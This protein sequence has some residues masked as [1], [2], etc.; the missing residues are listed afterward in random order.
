MTRALAIFVLVGACSG[1]DGGGSCPSYM[2]ISGGQ[3]SRTATRLTWTME[4][5][6]PPDTVTFNRTGVPPFVLEY[7]WAIDIDVDHDDDTDLRASVEHFREM[8]AAEVMTA[9]IL[10]VTNEGL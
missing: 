5:S 4:V 8:D 2:Q 3:F 6:A 9:D 7:Q 10:S 1:G